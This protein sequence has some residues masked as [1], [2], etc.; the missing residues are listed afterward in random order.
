MANWKHRNQPSENY[1]GAI[2]RGYDKA[3]QEGKE[4]TPSKIWDY[5]VMECLRTQGGFRTMFA[6]DSRKSVSRVGD[7]LEVIEAEL[8]PGLH[9]VRDNGKA[10]V[11]EVDFGNNQK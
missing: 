3:K 2:L 6:W 4:V 7:I 11:Q 1:L 8:V 9:I 10:L 5:V